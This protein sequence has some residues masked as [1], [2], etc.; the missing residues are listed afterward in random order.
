[1]LKESSIPLGLIL[2]PLAFYEKEISVLDYGDQEIPRCTFSSCRGYINPFVKWTDGGEKWICNLCKSINN[3]ESYYY[4]KLDKYNNR[5]DLN[6]NPF[7]HQG[8]FEF[9]ANKNIY[10]KKDKISNPPTF[11]FILDVS[12]ISIT[13]G[14][15][16]A[17][18]ESIKD[19]I[20]NDLILYPERTKVSYYI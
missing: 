10:L 2:N 13:H 11:V 15:L 1:M 16:S 8:S 19:T 6:E 17:V 3:T 5:V 12:L 9:I 18:I 7:L 20:N 14:F 4:A